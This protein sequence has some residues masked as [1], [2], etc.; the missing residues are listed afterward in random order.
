MSNI[1]ANCPAMTTITFWNTRNAIRATAASTSSSRNGMTAGLFFLNVFKCG[2]LYRV[3]SSVFVDFDISCD[4]RRGVLCVDLDSV[5]ITVSENILLEVNVSDILAC[6]VYGT[7]R[8][9]L[10]YLQD[11][12]RYHVIFRVTDTAPERVINAIIPPNTV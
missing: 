7:S 1:P 5:K 10:T 8:L 9:R 2:L 4:G 11:G 12:M 3:G 6:S